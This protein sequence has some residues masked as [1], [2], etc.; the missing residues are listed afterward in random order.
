MRPGALCDLR[1]QK[2]LHVW[3][4][5]WAVSLQQAEGSR[6]GEADAPRG[7]RGHGAAHDGDGDGEGGCGFNCTARLCDACNTLSTFA[8]P[9]PGRGP[10]WVELGSY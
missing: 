7:S 10:M 5:R 8:M 9:V 1:E 3:L 4:L 2:G 6:L